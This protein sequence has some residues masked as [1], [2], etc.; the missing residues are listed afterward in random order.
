MVSRSTSFSLR[1]DKTTLDKFL[2]ERRVSHIV[3]GS[4]RSARDRLR[5]SI[6][7]S[8]AA[9]HEEVWADKF[10][11]QIEDL[12]DL[13]DELAAR[14]SSALSVALN[15]NF[16]EIASKRP[17]NKLDVWELYQRANWH[18]N[19]FYEDE[20]A[21]SAERLFLAAIEQAPESA[22]SYSA[23]ATKLL[24]DVILRPSPENP[25]RLARALDLGNKAV[26][27]EPEDSAGHLAVGTVNM[28]LSERDT[29]L[30]ALARAVKLAPNSAD[31]HH[32]LGWALLT[33]GQ[34]EEAILPLER[35]LQLS[36]NDPRLFGFHL[37]LGIAHCLMGNTDRAQAILVEAVTMSP[38][39]IW[40]QAF[41]AVTL[42]LADKKL[43]GQKAL[44]KA[45]SIGLTRAS[46]IAATDTY[47]KEY[48]DVV[49][50]SLD[51]LELSDW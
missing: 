1:E 35:A 46:V 49:C 23:L 14:I 10:E 16:Q 9:K 48:A 28:W 32:G 33:F 42:S 25:E 39:D 34:I 37:Q 45:I 50:E 13:Q 24:Y 4:L 18:F 44:A 17:F 22:A 43:E 20:H 21:A 27:L 41:L 29:S 31:A 47:Q 5:I 51:A 30:A 36:P 19:K 6:S 15:K 26:R 40:G 11:A 38:D 2:S 8:H 12:F 7:L 3:E